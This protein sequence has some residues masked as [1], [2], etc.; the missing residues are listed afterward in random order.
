MSGMRY[1]K[2]GVGSCPDQEAGSQSLRTVNLNTLPFM[3]AASLLV[4]AGCGSG[5]RPSS[6]G[7]F[8]GIASSQG[9]V[10]V[11][12][13][14]KNSVT[15]VRLN[16]AIVVGGGSAE[17]TVRIAQ[18]APA[19]GIKVSLAS[20][21]PD[22]VRIPSS[23]EIAEGETSG[24]IQVPS[25]AVS[26][27]TSASI[28]ARYESS[29]A[30]A[31]LS[32]AP[33]TTVPFTVTVQPVTLTV[34]QG[35]AGYTQVA[36]KVAS[37]YNHSL[38]LKVTG[39]PTGVSVSLN[40]QTIPAPGSGT[41]RMTAKVQSSAAPGTYT[42][43]I[44][45]TDGTSSTA[46]KLTLQVTSA[47]ANPNATFKGCWHKQNGHRYQAVDISVGNP[48]TYLFDAVL[49]RGSTCDPNNFADQFGF[50]QLI[51]FGGFGYTFWFRDFADQTG[52]SALWYVGDQHSQCVNYSIAPDC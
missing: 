24:T 9:N 15:G 46:A 35:K 50:G 34:Q 43:K 12:A 8:A 22:L 37:G 7:S 17:I 52:M 2:C 51:N 41:S 18:P 10:V 31:N 16:P 30:G 11:G 14:Q 13:V 33:T 27:A 25:S 3:V 45:A 48:G 36:T 49:Y 28:V 21:E 38:Q 6:P 44:T 5:S 20:S 47:S 29:M 23:V 4:L 42:L 40:P 1:V 19:G 39:Q 32:L 26:V